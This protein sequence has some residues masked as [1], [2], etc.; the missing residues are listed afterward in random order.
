MTYIIKY[1]II[2][3]IKFCFKKKLLR[4]HEG[5]RERDTKGFRRRVEV[6]W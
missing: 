6:L 1:D 3:P 5:T 2:P 4:D